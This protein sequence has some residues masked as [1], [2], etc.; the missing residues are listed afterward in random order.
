VAQ[1]ELCNPICF[2][3]CGE[4]KSF[5]KDRVV[6]LDPCNKENNVA[7]K[8]SDQDCA[9]IVEKARAAWEALSYARNHGGKVQTLELWKEVFG[10]SF[11]I[12]E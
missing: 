4:V 11:V 12:E 10:R 8:I 6:I 2:P 9:A 7:C 5:P 1:T 3:E